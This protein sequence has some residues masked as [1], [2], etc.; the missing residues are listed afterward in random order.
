MNLRVQTV[1]PKKNS[2]ETEQEA[3]P[4]A[5]AVLKESCQCLSD[6]CDFVLTEQIEKKLPEVKVDRERIA[7]YQAEYEADY[8]DEEAEEEIDVEAD[9]EEGGETADPDQMDFHEE[10]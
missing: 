8:L 7:Q 3:R 1:R 5:V 6:I 4:T 2:K 10:Y 9:A